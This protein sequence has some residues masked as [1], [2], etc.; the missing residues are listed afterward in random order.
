MNFWKII[1]VTL[2][3]NKLQVDLVADNNNIQYYL[4]DLN[5]VEKGEVVSNFKTD[6]GIMFAKIIE[7]D[8]EN[9]DWKFRV[10]LPKPN[11]KE[12]SIVELD[13]YKNN[14]KYDSNILYKYEIPVCQN[15]FNYI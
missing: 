11:E 5:L 7:K 2:S 15:G 3:K 4:V 8:A 13:R 14:I 1:V 6:F 10:R 9:A 12:D